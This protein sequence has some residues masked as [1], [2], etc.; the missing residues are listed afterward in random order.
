MINYK[1]II[2]KNNSKKCLICG[3]EKGD[4]G[5]TILKN[6]ICES[7]IVEI[8]TLTVNDKRYHE[9]KDKLKGVLINYL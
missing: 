9:I 7:C 1:D 2:T 3:E 8:N 4:N 5:I 6:F